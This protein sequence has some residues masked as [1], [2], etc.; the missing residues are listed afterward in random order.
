MNDIYAANMLQ[1][2]LTDND[3]ASERPKILG[4]RDVN[5]SAPDQLREHKQRFRPDFVG[6]PI[7]FPL[8]LVE[9]PQ[10]G[11]AFGQLPIADHF[12]DNYAERGRAGSRRNG[13][14]THLPASTIETTRWLPP[15]VTLDPHA[16]GDAI[17]AYAIAAATTPALPRWRS[18]V[19]CRARSAAPHRSGSRTRAACSRRR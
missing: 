6:W 18:A 2:M 7:L 14:R 17:N 1:S 12:R 8:L 15:Q 3:I 5:K 9:C 13:P 11:H 19:P 16:C 10:V 4:A